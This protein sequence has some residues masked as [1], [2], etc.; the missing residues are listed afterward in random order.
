VI[1]RRI[2]VLAASAAAAGA[3]TAVP[4]ASDAARLP[5]ACFETPQFAIC[6]DDAGPLAQQALSDPVGTAQE[7]VGIVT[8]V[9][10][11]NDVEIC[12][13]QT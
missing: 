2:A 5:P 12:S 4:A 3:L 8:G 7:A 1:N 9:L 13:P 6:S 11:Y 10:C